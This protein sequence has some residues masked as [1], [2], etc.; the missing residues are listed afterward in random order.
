MRLSR[1]TP[2]VRAGIA[3]SL[4][5]GVV[6]LSGCG[7]STGS[8][9]GK[10]TF[11]GA[12]LKAGTVGFVDLSGKSV[13][14]AIDS[15]GRFLVRSIPAGE[16]TVTI[17][18]ASAKPHD[19]TGGYGTMPGKSAP[20]PLKAGAG[21]PPK[22]AQLPDGYTASNPAAAQA[23]QAGKNYVAIPLSYS[24]K[25]TSDLKYTVIAGEQTKDFDLK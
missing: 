21:A 9:S 20:P 14:G 13:G 19:A 17:E 23:S 25:E 15:E 4:F 1:V 10:V 22:D 5:A 16:Y 6:F 12:P 11:K 8:V 2:V 24:K 3:A 18:T 7:K